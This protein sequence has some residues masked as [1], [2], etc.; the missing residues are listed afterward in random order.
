MQI[1]LSQIAVSQYQDIYRAIK[2]DSTDLEKSID[3]VA[4]L[5]KKPRWEVEEMPYLEVNAMARD[6]TIAFAAD[7]FN[8]VPQDVI[9]LSDGKKY[10]ISHNVREMSAGQFI[11][12]VSFSK[13]DL[14]DSLHKSFACLLIPVGGK[15]DGEVHEAVS[16]M[17]AELPFQVVYSTC[18]FFCKLWQE[19]T[20]AIQPF[21]EEAMER[22]GQSH[23]DLW[24]LMAGFTTPN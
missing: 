19:C 11:D 13:G 3:I 1:A 10:R 22:K 7:Q 24:K 23:P 9:E 15:Y 4:A 14:I 6:I 20:K 16:E 18:V 5:T 2:S 17:V 12:F 8:Y 21:L